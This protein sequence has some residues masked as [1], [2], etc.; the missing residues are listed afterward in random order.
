[1]CGLAVP[2]VTV[3][4]IQPVVKLKSVLNV[5]HHAVETPLTS[6][7]DGLTCLTNVGM[8]E[9]AGFVVA[10]NPTTVCLLGQ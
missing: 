8:K 10:A 7:L 5:P 1:M 2:L 6:A 3:T 4:M 9:T